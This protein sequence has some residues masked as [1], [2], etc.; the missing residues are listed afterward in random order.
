MQA[1][2]NSAPQAVFVDRGC[3]GIEMPHVTIRRICELP[4]YWWPG[5]RIELPTRVF[6]TL[7]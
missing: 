7:E 3:Y 5:G 6:S 4:E 2:T 1:M